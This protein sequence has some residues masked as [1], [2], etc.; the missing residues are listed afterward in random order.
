M[1]GDQE[2]DERRSEMAQHS[3]E[4][5]VALDRLR[6]ATK[7]PFGLADRIRENPVPWVTAGLLLGLWLGSRRG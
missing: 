4:L 5:H 3:Q 1:I 7:R 6:A 2:L